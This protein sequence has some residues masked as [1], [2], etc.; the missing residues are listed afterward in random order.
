[1]KDK[2]SSLAAKN[3]RTF[4][5]NARKTSAATLGFIRLDMC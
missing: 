5:V 4:V 3:D 2:F 1:M